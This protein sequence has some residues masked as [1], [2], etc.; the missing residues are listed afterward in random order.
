ML[1]IP[2]GLFIEILRSF[3]KQVLLILS[4][5]A[6]YGALENPVTH[7]AICICM[8]VQLNICLSSLKKHIMGFT[9]G[10]EKF[11]LDKIHE[12]LKICCFP[13]LQDLKASTP[14]SLLRIHGSIW[15]LMAELVYFK[16][17]PQKGSLSNY[18]VLCSQSV[19]VVPLYRCKRDMTYLLHR[20]KYW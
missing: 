13:A 18:Y 10:I 8:Y 9:K 20:F 1:V 6:Y 14:L 17:N 7:I 12:C 2:V 11:L 15:L 3:L 4:P 5:S 19:E 16:K